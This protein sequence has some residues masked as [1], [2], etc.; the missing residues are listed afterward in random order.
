MKLSSQSLTD[1]AA[2]PGYY[3]FCVID[4]APGVHVAMSANRNPHLAWSDAPAG[5]KS[6]A[7]ICDDVPASATRSTRMAWKCPPICRT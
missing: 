2:I 6:F 7:M 4:P 1:G 5:T 3:A